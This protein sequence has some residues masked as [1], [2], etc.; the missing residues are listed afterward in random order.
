MEKTQT[1]AARLR[2]QAERLLQAL[3]AIPDPET[4]IEA[5][6]AAKA[7]LMVNKVMKEIGEGAEADAAL[8]PAEL[9]ANPVAIAEDVLKPMLETLRPY[10]EQRLH[11]LS[12]EWW[13]KALPGAK[14]AAWGD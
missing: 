14:E 12:R 6:R 9:Q 11:D 13:E 3:E 8:R 1:I 5:D 2:Q 4:F 10:F 7:W